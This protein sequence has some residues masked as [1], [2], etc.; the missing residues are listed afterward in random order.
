MADPILITV[1]AE[2][3]QAQRKLRR[4]GDDLRG[5]GRDADR[6]SRAGAGLSA[7]AKEQAR[8]LDQL[9]RVAKRATVGVAGLAAL[10]FREVVQAGMAYEK[11]MARVKAVTGATDKQFKTL[12]DQAKK[13]GADTKF[14]AGEAAKA[15]YELSAAGFSVA[16]TG[17]ALPGVLSLAAASGVELADA[18]EISSNALRGFGLEAKE[19]SHVADVM[20][21]AVNNSSLEMRDL[22]FSLK[23]IAPIART[24]GQSLEVMTAALSVM[25]DAGIKGEQAGT[26]LRGGLVRLVK[27]TKEVFEGFEML[28]LSAKSLQGPDGLKSLPDIVRILEKSTRDMG[29]ATRNTALASLFGTEALS[30][31][32]ALIDA[33]PE[34]IDRLTRANERADGQSKRTAETMNK[35]VAGAYENLRGSIET[36]EISLYQQFQKP[37]RETLLEG[38]KLV[39]TKGREIEE[40]LDRVTAMSE[41]KQGNIGQRVQLI[42]QELGKV[43]DKS[44]LDDKLGDAMVDGLNTALPVM[45]EGAG[46]LGVTAAK[47]F[48][49]GFLRSDPLGRALLGAYAAKK[50]GAFAALG[51]MLGRSSGAAATAAAA[52]AAGAGAR[53]GRLAA[54]GRFAGRGALLAAGAYAAIEGPAKRGEFDGIKISGDGKGGSLGNPVT[55]FLGNLGGNDGDKRIDKTKRLLEGLKQE[56]QELSLAGD[57]SGL[58]ATVERLR[59]MGT[60]FQRVEQNVDGEAFE[61]Y[62]DK[63]ESLRKRVEAFQKVAQHGIQINVD[64][65]VTEAGAE[66]VADAFRSLENRADLSM[67]GI[68]T[69]VRMNMRVIAREMTDGSA[70]SKEAVSRN[71]MIAADRIKYGMSLG[72][73]GTKEGLAEIKKLMRQALSQFGIT[74]KEA[75]RYMSGADTKTGKSDASSDSGVAGA[76]V[77]ALHRV[78]GDVGPDSVPMSVGGQRFVVAPGEDVAV[79]NRQQRAVLDS[80]LA[81]VG[82]L[83]GLFRAVSTP[84]NS[85]RG[86]AGGGLVGSGDRPIYAAGGFY[87]PSSAGGS[88]TSNR[89]ASSGSGIA[90]VAQGDI[91]ALG[92]RLQQMG[93]AVGE[94]PLFGGVSPTAHVPDS[95]HY[96]PGG[97]ALDINADTFPGGEMPALDKLAAMLAKAGW[98]YL[99]R[100][101]NHFDHLHVDT[102][103]GGGPLSGGVAAVA[104]KLKQVEWGGPAGPL[105]A[106]GQ[107]GLDAVTRAA[108][109]RLDSAAPAQEMGGV[110]SANASAGGTLDKA[111]IKSLWL[112]AGGDPGM[113]NLMAAIALA[114]SSGNPGITNSIGA[115]G[116]WQVIPST[117]A[118]FGFDWNRLTDPAYNAQA[119]VAIL[120]GQGLGAWEAYTRGMHTK[121]LAQGGLLGLD[122]GKLV[123]GTD[124]KSKDGK[125]VAKLLASKGEGYA[126][127]DEPV[128]LPRRPKKAGKNA[129]QK[130]AR[131]LFGKYKYKYSGSTLP[132]IEAAVEKAGS[133]GLL[134]KSL[135]AMAREHARSDE[136]QLI[137]QLLDTNPDGTPKLTQEQ[138]NERF[139]QLTGQHVGE[140]NAQLGIHDAIVGT[141][142]S[143]T[144]GI[145]AMVQTAATQLTQGLHERRERAE[146][147]LDAAQ[148]NARRLRNW[149][150][151]LEDEK[152]GTGGWK[153]KVSTNEERIDE[154]EDDLGAE[155]DRKGG[156]DRKVKRE[157]RDRISGLKKENS[158]LRR[159]KPAGGD[160][161]RKSRLRA[162]LDFGRDLQEELVGSR[163]V[164]RGEWEL[165]ADP[166]PSAGMYANTRQAIETF[167]TDLETL[168]SDYASSGFDIQAVRADRQDV[169]DEIAEWGGRASPTVDAA[170]AGTNDSALLALAEQEA[171]RLRRTLSLT[172]AQFDVLKNFQGPANL[173]YLGAFAKGT[174][175]VQQ[176]GLAIVHRDE[177]IGPA[178]NGAYGL[179][180]RMAARGAAERPIQIALYVDGD[181]APLMRKVR[182]TIDGQ[183][184]QISQQQG[185]RS[186]LL[187]IA[188]GRG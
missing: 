10:G 76:A 132:S 170:R 16:E 122:K 123:K 153:E 133:S 176:T 15:M 88:T 124:G 118:G 110:G 47:A 164:K 78:P 62:G 179:D 101:A 24:T 183:V 42:A 52:G 71:F 151:D 131:S 83:P 104:A 158:R 168:N 138:I 126:Q 64:S 103:S 56:I 163:S 51:T 147:I 93:Y 30:G 82:G 140:L 5:L 105:A 72:V 25:G 23:Y 146:D 3:D 108:Q 137:G 53:G 119:A 109:A 160:K 4:V 19:S 144:G 178:P 65:D 136:D 37:L 81:D 27:P 40:F 174:E 28:G 143:P 75:S 156:G 186:H 100:V 13:L 120:K 34:K 97:A 8:S 79:I 68:K 141:W 77:G 48:G 171:E 181:V 134:G 20:A 127:G 22:Q 50:L 73:I 111:A 157:L 41:F 36:V 169:L 96:R 91:V 161:D 60:E 128:R 43:V 21:T 39:N 85:P 69:A 154:L 139:A 167:K 188:P 92:R 45:A 14:S 9:G 130:A 129:G 84:H 74:G 86:M 98:H 55:R 155:I 165:R 7:M 70:E 49:D 12:G 112:G 180:Q 2:A 31:M 185:R 162:D 89:D 80:R 6:A 177:T 33:G 145:T 102:A 125:A 18:A 116:L 173:R 115:R 172:T 159:E 149:Q 66:R 99:W 182:A 59:A 58:N 38:A 94:H 1:D 26:T 54:A 46:K 61:K 35:T 121:F 175:R 114:E 63:V 148:R 166:S 107:A 95:Y 150:Q 152:R 113:A 117:A 135:A 32:L 184:A 90:G 106:M 17:K 187:T 11:E 57:S 67:G 29:Q 87:D 142:E 44:N